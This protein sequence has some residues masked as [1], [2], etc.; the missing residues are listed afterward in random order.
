MD[1]NHEDNEFQGNRNWEL[2][3]AEAIT[4]SSKR[5]QIPPVTRTDDLF[6]DSYQQ[7]TTT[8]DTKVG[9]RKDLKFLCIIDPSP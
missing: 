4:V 8:V 3:E 2:S 5:L 6:M 1:D 9:I 7:V